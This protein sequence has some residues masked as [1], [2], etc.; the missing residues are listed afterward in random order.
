M[1]V[2]YSQSAI[3][4]RLQ[5]VVSTVG[6]SGVLRLMDGI[7]VLSTI[8][9]ATPCGTVSGGVLTFTGPM[10]DQLAAVTG[11]VGA[12]AVEDAL[13]NIVIS[14]FTVGIPLSGAEVIVNNGINTLQILSGQTVTLL[15]AS[16][17]GS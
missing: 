9:L 12:A 4:G 8:P 5:A 13:G 15:S 10:T 17:T 1:P 7:A 6:S 2:V 11:T 3:D 14:G 16:I